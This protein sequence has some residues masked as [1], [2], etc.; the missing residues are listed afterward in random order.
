[1]FICQIALTQDQTYVRLRRTFAG[2][3]GHCHLRSS[4]SPT[5]ILTM[6]CQHLVQLSATSAARSKVEGLTSGK[7]L[8]PESLHGKEVRSRCV[9]NKALTDHGLE[10]DQRRETE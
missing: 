9:R 2:I 1:M 5:S 4:K 6:V 3:V 7:C 10:R 8:Q